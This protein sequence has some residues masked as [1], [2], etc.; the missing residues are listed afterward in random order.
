[1][2]L[3]QQQLTQDKARRI[4][5]SYRFMYVVSNVL[6]LEYMQHRDTHYGRPDIHNKIRLMT[7]SMD[8]VS[9]HLVGFVGD[10]ENEEVLEFTDLLA[11]VFKELVNLNKEEL[12][13]FVNQLK[14]IKQLI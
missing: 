1:M 6:Q 11:D 10:A 14:Q 13:V 8:A 7:Q 9:K 4:G 5:E 12:S 2:K 3:R